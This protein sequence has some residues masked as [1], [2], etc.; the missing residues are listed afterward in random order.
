MAI[1]RP[2]LKFLKGF[3]YVID[4]S[5]ASNAGHPLKFTADSGA[6]EYTLGVTVTG[7][8]G[9]AGAN[10]T[11][12]VP[13]NAPENMMYYCT[14]HGIGMG[15]KIR[16]IDDP[17]A[18]S[19]WNGSET[20]WNGNG[21]SLSAL[22]PNNPT[23]GTSID[24]STNLLSPNEWYP[25]AP[26]G[27]F[28]FSPDGRYFVATPYQSPVIRIFTLTTPFDLTSG[29]TAI[30]SYTR[31]GAQAPY[32]MHINEDGTK[33]YEGR[34]DTINEYTLSTPWDASTISLTHTLDT[35]SGNGQM[36]QMGST[37]INGMS[38][39]HLSSDGTKLITT[40]Q[41][42]SRIFIHNLNTPWSLSSIDTGSSKQ[43][44]TTDASLWIR[45]I[46]VSADGKTFVYQ[47]TN[48]ATGVVEKISW[49]SFATPFVFATTNV[50]GQI[51]TTDDDGMGFDI[52]SNGSGIFY[53]SLSDDKIWKFS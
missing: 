8:P 28:K 5:D 16:I 40:S 36:G 2:K 29:S 49:M 4:Q 46:V 3:T 25:G 39:V 27:P 10:T 47:E 11:F 24:L 45:G 48:K 42:H 38:G 53:G 43:W 9:Q 34:Y 33:L 51:I 32:D 6:T 41:N 15:Q 22:L 44:I 19:Y 52:A 7:T 17:N 31:T 21:Q 13:D 1:Q 26:S 37:T 35:S 23:T 18:V 20:D 30:T 50:G 12:V 14:T